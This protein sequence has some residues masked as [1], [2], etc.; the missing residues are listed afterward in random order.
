LHQTVCRLIDRGND[1]HI[2]GNVL[3]SADPAYVVFL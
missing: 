3:G 2:D 1:P